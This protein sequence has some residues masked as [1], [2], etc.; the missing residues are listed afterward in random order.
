M[1][2]T[3][4]IIGT[5]L[6]EQTALPPTAVD[7]VQKS[8]LI[9]GESRKRSLSLLARSGIR[10]PEDRVLF[11]DHACLSDIEMSLGAPET[12]SLFSDHGMPILF[13]PGREV[14]EICRKMAYTLRTISGPTSWG[15]A[16]AVS[17]FDPPFCLIGFLPQRVDER[18]RALS[19][20][21]LTNGHLVLL[22]TPYRLESLVRDLVRRFGE[23]QRA[24]M[25]WEI[26]TPSEFYRWDTLSKLHEL[27]RGIGKGRLV[28]ILQSP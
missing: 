3:L 1:N 12:V 27:A 28:L 2:R 20:I 13:D 16:C 17:G 22:E 4:Y 21:A 24:F 5:P 15:T 8:Q 10:P 25:A 11:L 6:D 23:A 7:A 26:G 18:R 19:R 9:I 14:L